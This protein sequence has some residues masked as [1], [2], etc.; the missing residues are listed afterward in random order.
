MTGP[1]FFTKMGNDIVSYPP[2]LDLEDLSVFAPA[3]GDDD[4]QG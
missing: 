1:T 3:C 2:L 4:T